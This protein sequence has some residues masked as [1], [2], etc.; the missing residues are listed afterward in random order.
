MAPSFATVAPN[1]MDPVK[2]FF[3]GLALWPPQ[4]HPPIVPLLGA[5]IIITMGVKGPSLGRPLLYPF[6]GKFAGEQ[7]G[8][9]YSLE[10]NMACS[11]LY[12]N[13]MIIT[14]EF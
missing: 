7:Y 14:L 1:R 3:G 12:F 5:L 9:P 13:L 2:L 4:I 10:I 6:L 11:L 8:A